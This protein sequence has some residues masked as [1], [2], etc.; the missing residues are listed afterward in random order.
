MLK[1][2]LGG[3]HLPPANAIPPPDTRNTIKLNARNLGK[4][5]ETIT[6][7]IKRIEKLEKE[8]ADLLK[9]ID[10]VR[11]SRGDSDYVRYLTNLAR[12]IENEN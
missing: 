2:K 11:E 7:L 3:T 6:S 4:N 8:K 10:D 9:A 1:M 12:K 5:Q